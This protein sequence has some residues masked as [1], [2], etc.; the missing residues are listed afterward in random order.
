MK[1]SKINAMKNVAQIKLARQAQ[2][3]AFISVT[4]GNEC[5]VIM[6]ADPAESMMRVGYRIGSRHPLDQGAA[7]IAIL[8]GRKALPNDSEAV[9]QAR[10]LGYSLTRGQL[11]PGAIG[12]A[13]PISCPHDQHSFEACVGVVALNSLDLDIAT[14]AVPRTAAII[15]QL[16][17]AAPT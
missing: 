7:G 10:E 15:T 12:V 4:Q 5:M 6:V 17:G 1:Y 9:I 2:A 14:Q 13:S 16:L 3:S 11:Q 8:S